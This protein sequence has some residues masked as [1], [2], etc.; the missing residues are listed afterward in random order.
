MRQQFEAPNAQG[1][2]EIRST[3]LKG[4]R[5]HIN[6]LY[7]LSF[8]EATLAAPIVRVDLSPYLVAGLNTIQYNV[9][10]RGGTAT[11]SVIVE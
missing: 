8:D 4:L 6:E 2:L 10:G 7:D 1:T 11:V 3:D 5:V 9:V